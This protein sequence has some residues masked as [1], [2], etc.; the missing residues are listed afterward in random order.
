MSTAIPSTFALMNDSMAGPTLVASPA[1]STT[2][3]VQPICFAASCM[4]AI[5]R[6]EPPLLAAR[7]TTPIV[8]APPPPVAGA[9]AAAEALGAAE[10][11]CRAGGRSARRERDRHDNGPQEDAR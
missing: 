7:E 1:V 2:F 3:T 9:E 11:E 6:A 4:A 10:A 8:L 5:M